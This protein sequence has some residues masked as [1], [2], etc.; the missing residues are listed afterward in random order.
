VRIALCLFV[1][2][3]AASCSRS[4]DSGHIAARFAPY[5]QG[6]WV[7]TDY[8]NDVAKTKSPFKSY[9]KLGG[10][11]S[12]LIDARDIAADSLQVGFSLNDHEGTEF[13]L[14]LRPGLLS[15]TLP[16]NL[17]DYDNPANF[18]ELGYTT[19]RSDTSL[20]L[21]HFSKEKKLLDSVRFTKVHQYVNSDGDVSEGIA[22]IVN[23]LLLA[24]NYSCIDSSGKSTVVNFSES[25]KVSGFDGFTNYMI[26]T[27]FLGPDQHDLLGFGNGNRADSIFYGWEM[28]NDSVLLYHTHEGQDQELVND[29]LKYILKK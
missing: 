10:V 21:Y 13:Y 12:L 6:T 11:V 2:F 23:K 14:F 28:R 27:D 8:I 18:Y 29:K 3:L 7:K 24:G 9:D 22:W 25:G 4:A 17:K 1:V 26:V 20:L 5:L 19:N 16:S 15:N